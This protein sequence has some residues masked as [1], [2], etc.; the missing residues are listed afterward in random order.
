MLFQT[1]NLFV[2][3]LALS[4]LLVG[5]NIPFYIS[6]YF[7]LPYRCNKVACLAR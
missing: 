7:D 6:F 3:A 5:I 4:D 1:H 2:A